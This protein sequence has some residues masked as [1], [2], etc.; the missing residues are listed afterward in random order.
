M[1]YICAY[2]FDIYICQRDVSTMSVN[3]GFQQGLLT[4]AANKDCQH[5]LSTMS[6]REGFYQNASF[7]KYINSLLI[8]FQIIYIFIRTKITL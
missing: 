7:K 5:W 6:V 1:Y 8:V 2:V 3:E 4:K